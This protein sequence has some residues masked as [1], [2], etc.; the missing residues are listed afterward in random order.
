MQNS[1]TNPLAPSQ[2]P[3]HR[4]IRVAKLMGHAHRRTRSMPWHSSV[5]VATAVA[6][7]LAGSVY[8]NENSDAVA[9]V[10]RMTPIGLLKVV[11][12][13]TF[14]ALMLPLLAFSATRA[15]T[16]PAVVV[17]IEISA[18]ATIAIIYEVSSRRH[19]KKWLA[20]P[21]HFKPA[22]IDRPKFARWDYLVGGGVAA[23]KPHAA[24]E[25]CRAIFDQSDLPIYLVAVSQVHARLYKRFGF[26]QVGP[27]YYGE[28][29]MSGAPDLILHNLPE[30]QEPLSKSV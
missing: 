26:E 1:L 4:A 6:A 21:G 7:T 15:W 14:A 11:I 8:S 3:V 5:T 22:R 30:V 12:R 10:W 23:T 9:I 18:M 17:G 19:R 2:V 24:D 29:P 27:S 28:V 16:I 13:M 20:Q 25:L